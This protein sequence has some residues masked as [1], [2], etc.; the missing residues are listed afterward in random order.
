MLPA[1][2]ASTVD[3]RNKFVGI[4][5]AERLEKKSDGEILNS[6]HENTSRS[7]S[8]AWQANAKLKEELKKLKGLGAEVEKLKA[9][10]AGKETEATMAVKSFKNSDEFK[11]LREE[12]FQ[13]WVCA[14]YDAIKLEN[15]DWDLGCF[16]EADDEVCS[17]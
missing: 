10:V 16:D 1:Y 11:V 2:I 4:R 9:E 8:R 12:M 15:L 3:T 7:S 5:V 14:L 6:N 13:A 17:S